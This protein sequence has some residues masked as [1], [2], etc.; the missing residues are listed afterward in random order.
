MKPRIFHLLICR[1]EAPL[2]DAR[3]P[4]IRVLGPSSKS[5]TAWQIW[6]VAR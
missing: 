6:Q 4:F 1:K 5:P 3:T 2:E